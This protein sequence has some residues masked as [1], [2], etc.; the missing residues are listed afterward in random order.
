MTLNTFSIAWR[1]AGL[2]SGRTSRA[3]WFSTSARPCLELPDRSPDALQQVHRLEPGDDDRDT[4][5]AGERMVFVIAHH[6]AHVPGG[7]ERLH[8]VAGRAEDRLHRGRHANVRD[9]QGEVLQAQ[10]LRLDAPRRRRW[11]RWSRSRRPGR[12]PGV[13]GCLRASS[14]ASS[15]R[16]DDPDVAPPAPHLEQVFMASRNAEHVAERGEDHLRPAGDCHRAV[17]RLQ[18]RHADRAART[19]NQLDLFG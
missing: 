11:A 19:V 4:E 1:A 18:G 6:R 10:P 5:S 3:Y 12:R 7:K 14:R 9:K 2:P 17:E 15:G 13:A 16:I 8:P